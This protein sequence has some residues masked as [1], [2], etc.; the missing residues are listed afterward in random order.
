[1]DERVNAEALRALTDDS[2]GRTEIVR[3]ARDLDPATTNIADEL[4]KQYS[5]GYPA[6]G[7]NDGR[8]HAITVQVRGE[9]Y[10]VRARRGYMASTN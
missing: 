4:S 8:W 10:T 6:P 3:W 7:K 5:L 2:G 9:G 1:V